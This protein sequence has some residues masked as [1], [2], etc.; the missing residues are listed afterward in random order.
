MNDIVFFRNDSKASTY[1]RFFNAILRSNGKPRSGL[2][3]E[4]VDSMILFFVNVFITMTSLSI[5]NETNMNRLFVNYCPMSNYVDEKRIYRINRKFGNL[6]LAKAQLVKW[7]SYN[8]LTAVLDRSVPLKVISLADIVI[9]IIYMNA[10]GAM[11]I[12][13]VFFI[14]VLRGE[15][16]YVK[17]IIS[18]Y[19]FLSGL[20]Y[21][22]VY[23]FKFQQRDFF[24]ERKKKYLGTCSTVVFR[25]K[26]KQ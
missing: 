15:P 12:N 23:E 3:V 4:I 20:R 11:K 17:S 6:Y 1:E 22:E 13:P 21:R 2:I 16:F 18:Q 8:C 5:Y 24:E 25:R 7:S 19:W 14:K 9:T 10:I 26:L